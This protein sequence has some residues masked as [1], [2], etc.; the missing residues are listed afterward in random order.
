MGDLWVAG[1]PWSDWNDD[2]QEERRWYDC[3]HIFTIRFQL[4]VCQ[5]LCIGMCM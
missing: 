1:G 5:L 2:L 4:G 3:D